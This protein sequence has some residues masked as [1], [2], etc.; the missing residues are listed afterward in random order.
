MC[1]FY[2]KGSFSYKFLYFL[3]FFRAFVV[4]MGYF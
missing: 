3:M 2:L 1:F 4:Q